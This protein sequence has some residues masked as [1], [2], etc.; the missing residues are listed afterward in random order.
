MEC[1]STRGWR[2]LLSFPLVYP[3]TWWWRLFSPPWGRN[4]QRVF[5]SGDLSISCSLESFQEIALLQSKY[6]LYVR[7]LTVLFSSLKSFERVSRKVKKHLT[8]QCADISATHDN[9]QR[10]Q[11]AERWGSRASNQKVTGSIPRCVKWCCVLG[12]GTSPYLSRG[13]CPCTYCK[14]LWIR[15]SAKCKFNNH[16]SSQDKTSSIQLHRLFI[17]FPILQRVYWPLQLKQFNLNQ[18]FFCNTYIF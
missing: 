9:N 11:M 14:L 2:P 6:L 1:I 18:M 15:A 7:R 13:E 10:S 17:C 5:H 4:S 8:N 16:M 3:A 12:Q